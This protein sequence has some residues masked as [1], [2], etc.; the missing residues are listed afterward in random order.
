M[1]LPQVRFTVRRMMVAIAAL[2]ILT[3]YVVIPAWDYYSLP[4]STR[5]V[6]SALGY[7]ARLPSTGPMPLVA[8]LKGIRVASAGTK[9]NGIPIY[10]DPNGLS[11]A[12]VGVQTTV[13][14]TN[15]RRPLKEQLER[16][17]KPL[18]LGY[19]VRDGLLTVTSAKSADRVLKDYPNEAKRP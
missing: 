4:P 10:V 12:G 13:V 17:L 16:S 19:F 18:G 6:L 5:A 3:Y 7:P 8:M 11:E 1:K 15:G 14:A 2:A 9:G